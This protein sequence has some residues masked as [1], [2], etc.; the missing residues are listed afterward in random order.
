MEGAVED[1]F[2]EPVGLKLTPQ[3]LARFRTVRQVDPPA[4]QFYLMGLS[5]DPTGQRE[6][7]TVLGYFKKAIEKDPGFAEAYLGLGRSYSLLGSNRW[8]RPREA[9][10]PSKQAIRKA[11][12]LDENNCR[13]HAI[14]RC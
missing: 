8:L 12:E 7:N 13:A 4:V 3:E 5:L 11:L 10:E 9:F 6:I 2:S 14:L 1:A